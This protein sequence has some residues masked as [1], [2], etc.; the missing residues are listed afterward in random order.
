MVV[1][2]WTWSDCGYNRD[3]I[4]HEKRLSQ[5]GGGP[6]VKCVSSRVP[7][8][9]LVDRGSE[10][11]KRVRVRKRLHNPFRLE[12]RQRTMGQKDGMFFRAAH[13]MAVM[14]AAS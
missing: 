6:P 4:A 5:L 1:V 3:S 7:L 14:W 13:V 10:W 8:P 12:L 11:E 2:C 9:F